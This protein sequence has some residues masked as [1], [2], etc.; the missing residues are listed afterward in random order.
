MMF[1]YPRFYF[2]L[3]FL[4]NFLN[5]APAQ[6]QFE[7]GGLIGVSGYLGDL[8]KS[9][10]FSVEPKLAYGALIRYNFSPRL[11]V[12]ASFLHGALSGRDSHYDDRAFRNFSTRSP[13]NELTLQMEWSLWR[14]L[15]KRVK[16]NFFP[17]FSPFVFVGGGA[18]YTNPKPNMSQMLVVKPD[19]AAGVAAD[20][21]AEYAKV[22]FIVPFG[23]GVKYR[24][25]PQWLLT[26]ESGFRM[27]SSDYLDG[28]SMAANPLKNDRYKYSAVTLAYRF[29][30]IPTKCSPNVAQ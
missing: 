18:V 19:I 4:L 27:S 3:A 10:W 28:I 24:F 22:H 9:D 30:R 17:L 20:I 26:V 14:M 21:A 12:R 15:P 8:N 29:S 1:L 2:L 5:P 11:A 23:I 16:L 13:F 25:Q 7:V 6:D